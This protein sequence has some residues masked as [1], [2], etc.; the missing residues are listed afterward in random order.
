MRKFSGGGDDV[1]GVV[2]SPMR[3]CRGDLAVQ[4]YC[5]VRL[6]DDMNNMYTAHI[7]A[8]ICSGNN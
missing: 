7:F 6:A 8:W 2:L 4:S 1:G 3:H 5:R